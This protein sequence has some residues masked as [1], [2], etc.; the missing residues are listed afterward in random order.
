M[1]QTQGRGGKFFKNYLLARQ[2]QNSI[3]SKVRYLERAPGWPARRTPQVASSA[4][5]KDQKYL[6]L[7]ITI[8]V[9][10]KQEEM[11]IILPPLQALDVRTA[12]YN[13]NVMV[14]FLPLE[15]W[16]K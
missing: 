12:P 6:V 3:Q 14:L 5:W 16:L 13:K 10:R 15:L 1:G 2:E 11:G 4:G 8:P 9:R 7:G